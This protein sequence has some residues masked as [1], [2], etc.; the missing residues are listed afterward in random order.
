MLI[1]RTIA[2][3]SSPDLSN[4]YPMVSCLSPLFVPLP[5][6]SNICPYVSS[7]SSVGLSYLV[8]PYL[9]QSGNTAK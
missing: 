2:R 4:I 8:C 5:F 6:I 9:L 7:P 1:L 3:H